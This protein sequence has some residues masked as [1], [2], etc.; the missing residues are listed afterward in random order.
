ML[1]RRLLARLG[2][3]RRP[4]AAAAA[5]GV[6]AA[7]PGAVAALHTSRAASA[8]VLC[9]L[10]PDPMAG[11]PPSYARDSIPAVAT[12]PDGTPAPAMPPGSGA[13]GTLLGCVSGAL[14]LRD[15]LKTQGHELIVTSDKCARAR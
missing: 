2:A 4:G 3:A 13:P 5:T 11:Y 14:G 7:A 10:Y 8:K 15:F 6:A 9:V 12:Y 1:A